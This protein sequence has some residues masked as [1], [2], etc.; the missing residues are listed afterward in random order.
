MSKMMIGYPNWLDHTSTALSG[1]S[2]ETDLPLA[3]LQDAS[4]AEVARSTD[5]ASASTLVNV[6]LSAQRLIYVF[7][8]VA[9]NMSV[10]ALVRV[11]LG[12]DDTF[13]SSNY[14]TGWVYA[15]P[16]I[17]PAGMPLWGYAGVWNGRLA[18]DDRL[19]G[20]TMG[21]PHVL[22]TPTNGRYLRIE[23]DDTSNPDTYV[24][25]G[26]VVIAS[27]FQ[28]TINMRVGM[29]LG[30]EDLSTDTQSDGGTVFHDER[31]RRRASTFLLADQTE[32][33]AMVYHYEINRLL[34]TFEQFYFI[35]DA[36]D[37]TY[38]S[39]R[40]WLAT[41][42]KLSRMTIGYGSRMDQPVEVVEEL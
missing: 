21:W 35:Y 27:G 18:E 24:E 1:G 33:E 13:A 4:L 6:D 34:G 36:A 17:Y 37:T 5:D 30:F 32:A 39:R 20:H 22:S 10:D 25:I 38:L 12:D 9:H 2:W 41:M 8:V 31:P 28:P 23:I 42:R 29:T 11:R 14:D 40:S 3:N 7:A 15:Y 16:I 19:A 26:R